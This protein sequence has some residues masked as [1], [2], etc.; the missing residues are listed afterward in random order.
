MEPD[1]LYLN[2]ELQ[3]V[4]ISPSVLMEILSHYQHRHVDEPRAIGFLMGKM[5]T[6]AHLVYV[7]DC[8]PW[9]SV[10]SF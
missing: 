3:E 5:D 10:I 8:V 2:G 7:A 6:N 9:T 1:C 4:G